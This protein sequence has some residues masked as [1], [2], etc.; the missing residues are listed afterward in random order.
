MSAEYTR[1]DTA[2]LSLNGSSLA[3]APLQVGQQLIG[4]P[5]NSGGYNLTWRHGRLML[6]T[7]AYIRGS[8][9][10][11]EPNYGLSACALD[12]P[13][14]FPDKGYVRVDGGFA[15]RLPRGF[16]IYG[17]LDNLLNRKYEEVLG[18]P[19]LPFNFLAGVRFGFPGR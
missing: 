8:V 9:L 15:Y 12:L 13:C 6:N 19:S 2:V 10:D 11:V 17:R 14:L 16:E 7:N 4:Q 3:L 18:Y 5:R 1:D